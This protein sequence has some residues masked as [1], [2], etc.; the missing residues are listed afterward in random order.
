MELVEKK[1]KVSVCVMAYNQEK[2]IRQ[3]LQSLVDQQTDFEFEVIVSDDCSTDGTTAIVYEFAEKYKS[4]VRAIVHDSNI[5]PYKNYQY[6]HQQAIG[7]YVAHIDGDDYAL[8]GKLAAQVFILDQYPDVALST[9]AV[10]VEG[11]ARVM[12]N[13]NGLPETGSIFD[14]LTLGTYFVNS[15]SMYRR[16]NS[17]SHDNDKEIID[18]YCHIEHASKGK[19]N[20]IKTPLGAYRWHPA[21]VS[22]NP[23]YQERIERSYEMAFDRALEL[24][25][26]SDVVE[27]ARLARRKSFAIARLLLGDVAGFR[28]K[29]SLETNQYKFVSRKHLALN[30][31]RYFIFGSFVISI[32]KKLVEIK[33]NSPNDK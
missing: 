10:I 26:P 8:P 1:P 12:G 28:K 31:G 20:L 25:I 18:Y 5:G 29:I 24:N 13:S 33:I 30:F 4:I 2:Y 15:S 23:N 27:I 11:T 3:C 17:F 21:G 22:K 16:I 7:E 32:F 14:L 19:I 6:V 9:H